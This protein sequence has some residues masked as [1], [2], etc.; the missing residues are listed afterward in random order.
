MVESTSACAA[1]LMQSF[2]RICDDTRPAPSETRIALVRGSLAANRYSPNDVSLS[3]Y[4]R[5][6]AGL[7]AYL[8]LQI[9]LRGVNAGCITLSCFKMTIPSSAQKPEQTLFTGQ[10]RRGGIA[11]QIPICQGNSETRVDPKWQSQHC[12]E[13][14]PRYA[15]IAATHGCF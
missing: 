10:E 13:A 1:K 9:L 6:I 3:F 14:E 12:R 15:E 2:A 4:E 7:S 8:N 5:K 11:A